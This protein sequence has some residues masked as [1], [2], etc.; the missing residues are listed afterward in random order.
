MYTFTHIN[1]IIYERMQGPNEMLI[2]GIHKDYDITDRLGELSV[3]R[4]SCAAATGSTRPEDT[5]WYHSLVPHAEL[6]V[7]EHSSHLPHLEESE[8]YLQALRSFV[9]RAERTPQAA[10]R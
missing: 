8:H 6:V 1:Q 3:P 7:F 5:A 2:T 9:H 10:G 4:C